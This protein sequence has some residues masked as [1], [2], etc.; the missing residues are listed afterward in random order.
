MVGTILLI[1]YQLRSVMKKKLIQINTVC[2]GSTGNIMR[3][4][5]IEAQNQGYETISFHGRRKGYADLP[6]ER[7][8]S[9]VG[10]GAHVIWNII[11]DKQGQFSYFYTRKM[12]KRLR[13]ERPDIIHL[14]NL[15]GYYLNYP[16]F[17]SY[18]RE[19]FKGKIVWTFHDCWSVTGHCPYFVIAK[20]NKWKYGCSKCPN[21]GVYPISW[22]VDSSKANYV[23]KK[24]MF[25]GFSNMTIVCPSVWMQDIVKQSFLKDTLNVV[26]SNGIDF[27]VFY[28]RQSKRALEKYKIPTDKK[29]I[30]GVAN[31]WEER[32]GLGVFLNLAKELEENSIFV[33]VGLNTKQKK[34]M[35][36]NMI[37]IERTENK[38]ELAEI[39]TRADVF[40]NPSQEESFSLVTVE[41]MAC[42][43]PVVALDSSAVKELVNDENGIVLHEPDIKDY[44]RAITICEKKKACAEKII[45]SVQKYS[46]ENMTRNIMKIY[47][48]EINENN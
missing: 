22:F 48:E 17:F 37:G 38:D 23:M 4:I 10:F 26:V 45:E 21:K 14:H 32:K 3:Q 11:T 2:N 6:C 33:L 42:G 35:L 46:V 7:F 40:L 31:I 47:Q 30:L 19:E 9:F 36:P 20:C 24:K 39:Y 34:K 29:V 15:H 8:G 44:I 41:A 18:L 12:L 28:P 1:A 27:E 13:Q 5:Q 16:L 25:S 43:T